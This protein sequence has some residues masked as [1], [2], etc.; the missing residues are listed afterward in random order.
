MKGWGELTFLGNREGR[1]EE[2]EEEKEEK[3]EKKFLPLLPGIEARRGT[4]LFLPTFLPL[5]SGIEVRRGTKYFC[6]PLQRREGTKYPIKGW[7][8]LTFLGNREGRE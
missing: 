6:P 3:E 2:R 4:K 1:E 7:G 8:E 5:L